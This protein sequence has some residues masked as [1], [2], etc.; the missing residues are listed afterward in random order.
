MT[1]RTT[2]CYI[3]VFNFIET[4]ILKLGPNLFMTD[5][6]GGLRKAL[7]IC[8][9]NA[10]LK[11]CWFHYTQALRK[12]AIRFGLSALLKENSIAKQILRSLMCLPLLPPNKILEGYQCIKQCAADNRLMGKFRRFFGY[13]ESYW[14]VQVTNF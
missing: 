3:D 4:K 11:G 8:F 10:A 1:N 2:E 6:E 7:A 12:N 14:L 13:F 5:F 9:P